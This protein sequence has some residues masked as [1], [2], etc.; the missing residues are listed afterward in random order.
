MKKGQVAVLIVVILLIVVV[1]VGYFVLKPRVIVN[2]E[3]NSSN[4]YLDSPFGVEGYDP[5]YSTYIGQHWDTGIMFLQQV[6]QQVDRN[7]QVTYDYT[8][9]LKG[10]PSFDEMVLSVPSS[11]HILGDIRPINSVGPEDT[12]KALLPFDNAGLELYKDF[13]VNIVNRYKNSVNYWMA[14]SEPGLNQNYTEYFDYTC[15]IIKQTNPNAKVILG[16]FGPFGGGLS[17]ED[18]IN[19]IAV[20]LYNG[21]L[22]QID[23]SCIDIFDLHYYNNGRNDYRNMKVVYNYFREKLDE[24]GLTNVEIWS[25]GMGSFSD[26]FGTSAADKNGVPIGEPKTHTQA[27]QAAEIVKVYSYWTALGIKKIFSAMGP[28]DESVQATGD[29]YFSH[30]GFVYNGVNPS[31]IPAGT[32]KLSYYS[33]RLMTQ[34]LEGSDWN[35]IQTVMEDENN[36]VYV[37]AFTNKSTGKKTYV[38]WCDYWNNPSLTTQAQIPV[39]FS[40]NAKI[41]EAVPKY[42]QGKDVTDFN[43]AFNSGVLKITG[44]KITITLGQSPVY[45]QETTESLSSYLPHAWQEATDYKTLE[46]VNTGNT[47]TNDTRPPINDSSGRDSGTSSSCG[48]GLVLCSTT[49]KCS[50]GGEKTVSG[51][52]CAPGSC[53]NI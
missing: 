8:S 5:T 24:R 50:S 38:A 25:T 11:V 16:A 22:S 17:V 29:N 52:C 2:P 30:T 26:S 45:I 7:G 44:G 39:S 43:S 20:P 36:H 9:S 32:K 35:N 46:D 23:D 10:G 13:L 42:E 53:V 27:F 37:Y 4:N 49:E 33:Y 51:W 34:K 48:S 31:S 14:K 19:N 47:N 12:S 41:T 40:G 28:D 1:V 18:Q 15:P 6:L 21:I 3:Q